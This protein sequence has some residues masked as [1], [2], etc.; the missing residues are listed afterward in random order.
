M[1]ILSLVVDK[2]I[3][4]GRAAIWSCGEDNYGSIIIAQKLGFEEHKKLHYLIPTN[5][6]S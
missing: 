1:I 6:K 3:S 4:T 5:H 2:V